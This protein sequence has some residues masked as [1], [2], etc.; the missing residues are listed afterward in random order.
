LFLDFVKRFHARLPEARSD[1][2]FHHHGILTENSKE[3]KATIY[4]F[5]FAGV[6]YI[7]EIRIKP[8]LLGPKF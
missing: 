2:L 5:V 6:M 8:P 4:L 1:T 7:L 3:K